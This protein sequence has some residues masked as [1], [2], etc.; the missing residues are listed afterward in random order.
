MVEYWNIES[1]N[2]FFSNISVLASKNNIVSKLRSRLSGGWG[3]K[4]LSEIYPKYKEFFEPEI[5]EKEGRKTL[6]KPWFLRFFGV[7]F[8]SYGQR[9]TDYNGIVFRIEEGTGLED[10]TI[11]LPYV[12]GPFEYFSATRADEILKL[13]RDKGFRIEEKKMFEIELSSPDEVAEKVVS[14]FEYV[15][16]SI[17]RHELMRFT[18]TLSNGTTERYAKLC[19]EKFDDALIFDKLAFKREPNFGLLVA[20]G[21]GTLSGELGNLWNELTAYYKIEEVVKCIGIEPIPNPQKEYLQQAYYSYKEGIQEGKF[22][23]TKNLIEK[24][25]EVSKGELPYNERIG[26][27]AQKTDVRIGDI[28]RG[29]SP[30]LFLGILNYEGGIIR[31]DKLR[32]LEKE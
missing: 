19:Y 7:E 23:D 9:I 26:D 28:L 16:N 12:A 14:F 1:W 13:A 32:E 31:F 11:V 8:E 2:E 4:K 6:I 20:G 25:R 10:V 3:G 18:L 24:L 5:E 22:E 29:L 21:H 27:I 15:I 30:L 17:I